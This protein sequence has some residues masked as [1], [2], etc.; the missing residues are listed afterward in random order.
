M[1]AAAQS[2][3]PETPRSAKG[4]EVISVEQARGLVGKA[5]FFDMRSAVNFGRGHVPG[6]SALP[7]GQKSALSEAFDGS[8]DKFNLDK[9]PADRKA[10]VVF[11]SD[12]P[13]G[14]KS[15]KAAVLAARAGYSNVKWMRDGTSG[16]LAKGYPLE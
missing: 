6:A 3:P 7:Y 10:P 12:G 2:N 1:S 16:W 4:I 14:W 9:L 5:A 13:A 11:Y 8:Q 15:Y